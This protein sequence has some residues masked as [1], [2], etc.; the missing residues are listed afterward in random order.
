[1][2]F[3]L[4][5]VGTGLTATFSVHLGSVL[6]QARW[7][8]IPCINVYEHPLIRGF[9]VNGGLAAVPDGP[10]LGVEIDG[11]ALE[12]YRVEADFKHPERRQI[13]TIHWPAGGDTHHPDGG[14]RQDFLDGKRIGW[15]PGISLDVRLDD[16]SDEFDRD[17]R[18]LFPNAS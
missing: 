2:P 12:R 13:H 15:L 18:R 10:G 17:Y 9:E 14:Y 1:M 8:A 4:Q 5:L 16:G 3:W 6:E 11:D 7:P